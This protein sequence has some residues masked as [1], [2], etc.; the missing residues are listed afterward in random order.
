[1]KFYKIFSNEKSSYLQ[2]WCV[3]YYKGR[4]KREDI[5]E[6]RF[7]RW[8]VVIFRNPTKRVVSSL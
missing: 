1:M 3:R 6:T 2:T 4:I 8:I 5:G 7:F